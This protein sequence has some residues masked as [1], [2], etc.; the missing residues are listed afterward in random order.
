MKVVLCIITEHVTSECQMLPDRAKGPYLAPRQ[1]FIGQPQGIP[2]RC[3]EQG[4]EGGVWCVDFHAIKVCVPT[5]QNNKAQGKRALAS[6]TL[7]WQAHDTPSL[8]EP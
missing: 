4:A 1:S 5:G 7:G 6:A 8:A 3:A 2:H